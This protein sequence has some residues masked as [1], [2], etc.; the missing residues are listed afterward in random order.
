[1]E[2]VEGLELRTKHLVNTAA[3]IL[4]MK[5]IQ[6]GDSQPIEEEKMEL[7]EGVVYFNGD[8]FSDKIDLSTIESPSNMVEAK[9]K[10]VGADK[11]S[12]FRITGLSGSKQSANRLLQFISKEIAAGQLTYINFY[13]WSG[14]AS[15]IQR[16]T[17]A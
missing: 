5:L 7:L 2:G 1:M 12:K 11:L 10:I 6:L 14:E 4:E 3:N 9:N 15:E 17:L 8:V 16:E 13:D